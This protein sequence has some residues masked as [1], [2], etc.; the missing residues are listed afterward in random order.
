M[1]VGEH[2][3]KQ[4]PSLLDQVADVRIDQINAG[5][6]LLPGDR[7][8]EIDRQPRPPA[9]GTE[10]VDA[11]IHSYLPHAAE[12]G[13]DE[14]I[15]GR[16]HAGTGNTSPAAIVRVV[17][18]G[19]ASTRWPAA[20]TSANRPAISSVPA[21]TRISPATVTWRSQSAR[22]AA[23]PLPRSHCASRA[24]MARDSAAN[25]RSGDAGTPAAAKSVAG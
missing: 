16:G 23:K 21:A 5:Q 14:L 15:L 3:A 18:S 9:L 4:V 1:G 19:S 25:I 10:P 24:S 17:P 22:V 12:R 13:E 20:S 8:A 11:E 7:H 6:V 2:D